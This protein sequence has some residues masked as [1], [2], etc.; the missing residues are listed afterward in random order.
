MQESSGCLELIRDTQAPRHTSATQ[1]DIEAASA[2]AVVTMRLSQAVLVSPLWPG[3]L[4]LDAEAPSCAMPKVRSG[5]FRNSES[6]IASLDPH[7]SRSTKYLYKNL[8]RH[9]PQDLMLIN[10]AAMAS[11]RVFGINELLEQILLAL[12]EILPSHTTA[13]RTSYSCFSAPTSPSETPSD[14]QNGKWTMLTYLQQL[15]TISTPA[16][17]VDTSSY[18]PLLWMADWMTLFHNHW[19]VVKQD[20]IQYEVLQLRKIYRMH[21]VYLPKAL[22]PEFRQNS[23]SAEASWRR[24]SI[25]TAVYPRE[26][27]VKF[28]MT[29]E[30]DTTSV[31]RAFKPATNATLGEIYDAVVGTLEWR[32]NEKFLEEDRNRFHPRSLSTGDLFRKLT[33][34]L[35]VVGSAGTRSIM[36]VLGCGTF[37]EGSSKETIANSELE[38]TFLTL[39]LQVPDQ[40]L[41]VVCEVYLVS[42]CLRGSVEGTLKLPF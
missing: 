10:T 9:A 28:Q 33:E 8:Q 11:T 39:Q 30:G 13:Q 26:L 41:N 31:W 37:E 15:I 7:G 21:P 16:Q 14:A 19:S 40:P 1:A 23:A 35:E 24:L 34:K 32:N 29:L 25:S 22:R 20:E 3:S 42:A 36:E 2:P 6:Q 18:A 27:M 38:S 4:I 12:T 5:S 17:H